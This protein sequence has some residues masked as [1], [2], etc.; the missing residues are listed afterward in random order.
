MVTDTVLDDRKRDIKSRK[1]F[2]KNKKQIS[3]LFVNNAMCKKRFEYIGLPGNVLL[4][5]VKVI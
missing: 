3:K 5:P 4:G 2:F 1:S